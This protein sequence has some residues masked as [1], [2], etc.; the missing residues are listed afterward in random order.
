VVGTRCEK[1]SRKK[2]ED[3][4]EEMEFKIYDNDPTQHHAASSLK[5]KPNPTEHHHTHEK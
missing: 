5:R 4:H 2:N 3:I 1:L